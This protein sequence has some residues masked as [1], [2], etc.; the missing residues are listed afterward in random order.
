MPSQSQNHARASPKKK[1]KR[2]A[3]D[4]DGQR[5]S[6]KRTRAGAEAPLVL[7]PTPD[8]TNSQA[9]PPRRSGRHGAGQG[10]RASQLEIIGNLLGASTRTS[11]P[12]GS[13]SLDSDVPNNPLAP[14][15]PRKGRGSHSKAYNAGY[16]FRSPPPPYS[17][18]KMTDSAASGPR[19]KKTKATKN[20]APPALDF[21]APNLQPRLVHREA[22][23]RFG[24]AQ[25]IVPP[26]TE[27]DLQ[28]LNNS[29]VAA[30]REKQTSSATLGTTGH[31]PIAVVTSENQ[32]SVVPSNRTLPAHQSDADSDLYQNL[33]P[34]LRP[35]NDERFDQYEPQD[36]RSDSS[37]TSS[38]GGDGSASDEEADHTDDNVGWGAAHGR[39]TAHPGFSKED[40]PSQPR[41]ALAL[42]TDFEFQ[43]SRDEGDNDAERSLVANNSSSDDDTVT[44]PADPQPDDVLQL[45]HK[46]NGR[47]R[48]PDPQFLELL[49]HA[50]TKKPNHKSSNTQA[51]TALAKSDEPGEGPKAT[52]LGWYGPRWKSF[53]E[54]TK[55]ECRVQ[56]AIE[57]P[58]PKL[59]KD[60]TGSVNEVLMASL[61]EWLES[62]QHVEEGIWPDHKHDMAKLLYEDLSTWRSDLKK[63]VINIVPS[64]YNLIPPPH[65]PP[66]QRA[67]WV[68]AAAGELLEDAKFLRNGLDDL[69]KTQ[70]AAHPALR[71]AVISFF[72][73]SSYRVA[74]RRPE[75]FRTQLPLECLALVC[76]AVNCVLDG[77]AKNGS[78]KSFPKFTAKEYGSLYSLTVTKL[79]GILEHS[80]HGPKLVQQLRSWAR[81]GWQGL[82]FRDV[83]H[84]DEVRTGRNPTRWMAASMM[85]RSIRI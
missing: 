70:N 49:H 35:V 18:S 69:G 11:R 85:L 73:T 15:P 21:E 2:K 1:T 32:H 60:L 29:Y 64:M 83:L 36:T 78:G 26:G 66:Q 45:H 53:L 67:A 41:V 50:E 44:Q 38:E 24:F 80:Y 14:E 59:V 9:V 4:S 12:K 84:T 3:I 30:A 7:Q 5:V 19:A 58:F 23:A 82:L 8:V 79:Q 31:L 42:P 37:G 77:L 51:K 47:P 20:A 55:G 28:A 22:G 54:D 75:I 74:R 71:E 65:I 27:P 56:H 33:D 76:T 46:K 68:T 72:Y 57:N 6:T 63:I 61:V 17:A 52:Q 43:H 40:L 48:L 10:G 34:A 25:H 16:I 13:T 62:G 39:M 81:A